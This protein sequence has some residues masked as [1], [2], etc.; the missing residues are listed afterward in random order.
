M[1]SFFRWDVRGGEKPGF[2]R[3]YRVVARNRVFSRILRYSRRYCE[4]PGFFGIYAWRETGFF[5][6]M[7]IHRLKTAKN[8]VS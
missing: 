1:T 4:K 2:F 8:P 3:E 7:S 6:R 5:S